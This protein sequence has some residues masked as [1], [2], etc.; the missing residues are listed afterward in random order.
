MPRF[1]LL[2]HTDAPDDPAGRHFDLLLEAG[3]ACR[4][5]RLFDVPQAGGPA[6]AA[7]E[8]PPHRLVWLDRV[9]G[10][11]SGG[12]GFA[13]RVDAGTFEPLALDADSVAAATVLV[14]QLAGVRFGGRLRLESIADG[15]SAIVAAV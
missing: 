5:W 3:E 15:W 14:L 1:A 9:E 13:R 12:R 2:E 7:L 11:V 6:V 10:A 8:L 4:T